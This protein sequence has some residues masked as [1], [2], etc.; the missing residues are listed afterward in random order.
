MYGRKVELY[1]NGVEKTIIKMEK[2]MHHRVRMTSKINALPFHIIE[3]SAKP[4]VLYKGFMFLSCKSYFPGFLQKLHHSL[5]TTRKMT[6]FALSVSPFFNP[7]RRLAHNLIQ[8]NGVKAGQ[9][10]SNQDR[11]GQRF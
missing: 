5:K 4:Q 7:K 1:R 10:T 11:A 2:Y 9:T 8:K 3:F 6:S